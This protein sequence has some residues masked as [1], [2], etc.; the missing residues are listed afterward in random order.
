MAKKKKH[1]DYSPSLSCSTSDEDDYYEPGGI[2]NWL[3]EPFFFRRW[4][5]ILVFIIFLCLT[6][7][8]EIYSFIKRINISFN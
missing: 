6:Y 4:S 2:K 1:L 5:L 7:L 3:S 8:P